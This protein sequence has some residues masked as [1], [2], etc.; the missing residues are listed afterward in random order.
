MKMKK[1]L[2][3]LALSLGLAAPT[4]ALAAITATPAEA[5]GS[6]CVTRTEFRNVSRGMTLARVVRIF[7]SRGRTTFQ[8]SG[9][10]QK[11]WNTCTSRYG[12]VFVDFERRN[13]AFRVDSKT[14]YWG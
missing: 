10:K 5:G 7:D 14:A 9:Y 12:F 11:E 1:L 3:T 6:P 8:M 2:T 13:G 4:V